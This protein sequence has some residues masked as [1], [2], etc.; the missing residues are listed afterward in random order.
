MVGLVAGLGLPPLLFGVFLALVGNGDG[1]ALILLP[2][3]MAVGGPLAAF[4]ATIK[5]LDKDVPKQAAVRTALVVTG[6]ISLAFWALVLIIFGLC[7]AL[8]AGA[9]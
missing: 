1:P 6:W 9:Y 4:I 2:I 8:L 5:A 3:F 7:I